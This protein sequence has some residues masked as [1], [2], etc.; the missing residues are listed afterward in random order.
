MT[1]LPGRAGMSAGP[2]RESDRPDPR[3]VLGTGQVAVEHPADRVAG[4][5]LQDRV[6]AS[7]CVPAAHAARGTS[8]HDRS[9]GPIRA[10]PST[11]GRRADHVQAAGEQAVIERPVEGDL[12]RLAPSGRRDG[13]RPV[14]RVDVA[15]LVAADLV[16]PLRRRPGAGPPR[17]AEP[18]VDDEPE[19]L[20]RRSG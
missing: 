7:W 5:V 12:Q 1:R 2:E 3:F 11:G 19:R 8:R 17:V 13:Q 4:Q 6:D 20:A 10:V 15:A 9:P 18:G 16:P 14:G